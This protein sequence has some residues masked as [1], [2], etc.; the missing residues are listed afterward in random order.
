MRTVTGLKYRDLFMENS[1]IYVNKTESWVFWQCGIVSRV[2]GSIHYVLEEYLIQ[3]KLCV[4]GSVIQIAYSG[5]EE[6]RST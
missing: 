4:C 1:T 6:N 2:Y 5:A 3:S